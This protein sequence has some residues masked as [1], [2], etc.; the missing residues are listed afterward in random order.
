[1]DFSHVVHLPNSF[2]DSTT[3]A[4]VA[5]ALFV[6]LMLYLGL[7]GKLA[8]ALDKRADTIKA[9]LEEAKRLRE[10]AQELLARY[11]RRQREAEAEAAAIIDQARRSANDMAEAARVE[12][13]DQLARRAA[14]AERRIEQA[15]AS[16]LA[17]VRG[18]ASDV[19]AAAAERL[20][21]DRLGAD[22]QARLFSQSVAEL[23]D[24][25]G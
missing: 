11:Q 18:E 4:L 8:Q 17:L 23:T 14:L 6:A 5:L 7:P 24:R 13:Q 10:E 15:E 9:E 3:W 22:A 1:M 21:R 20:L 25:L 19:A 2:Y 12:M 16:A